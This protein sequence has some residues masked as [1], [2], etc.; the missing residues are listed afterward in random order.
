MET[1]N[2]PKFNIPDLRQ[3]PLTPT[4]FQEWVLANVKELLDCGQLAR[5]SKQS[6]RQPV[7]ARFVLR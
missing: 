7:N 5:V 2:L 1:L 3:K 6:T 4:E